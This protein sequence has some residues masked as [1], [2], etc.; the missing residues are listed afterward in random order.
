MD[1]LF[2]QS[3]VCMASSDSDLFLWFCLPLPGLPLIETLFTHNKVS[4]LII[5]LGAAGLGEG[6]GLVARHVCPCRLLLQLL[7]AECEAVR[8]RISTSK[9][10]VM[11]LTVERNHTSAR[12]A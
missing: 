11:V 10:N 5:F 6:S 7:A 3:L 2:T 9:S 4:N 12:G 1:Q 8:I